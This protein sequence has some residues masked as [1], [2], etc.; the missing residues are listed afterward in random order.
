[1]ASRIGHGILAGAVLSLLSWNGNTNP[2]LVSTF[3]DAITFAAVPILVCAGLWAHGRRTRLHDRDAIR[4]AG[5]VITLTTGVVFA[6]GTA[7][8]TVSRMGSVSPMIVAFGLASALVFTVV[9]G[10]VGTAI[11]THFLVMNRRAPDART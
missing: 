3:P 2:H 8:T 1:M 10:A 11:A 5:A 7:L 4:R 6:A 9:L